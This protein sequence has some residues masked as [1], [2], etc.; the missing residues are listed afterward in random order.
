MEQHWIYLYKNIRALSYCFIF[1][2]VLV[3]DLLAS[4][5]NG[6]NFHQDSCREY[7]HGEERILSVPFI[8]IEVFSMSVYS[9]QCRYKVKRQ[10][11]Q[12]YIASVAL[13]FS[14][15]LIYFNGLVPKGQ[16]HEYYLKKVRGCIAK[17]NHKIIGENGKQILINIED[18][19]VVRETN[20]S[21]PQHSIQIH[22]QYNILSS[23]KSFYAYIGCTGIFHEIMHYFCLGDEYNAHLGQFFPLVSRDTEDRTL[24]DCRV[25]QENSIMSGSMNLIK[26]WSIVFDDP[27]DHGFQWRSPLHCEE[28]TL[29]NED[30]KYSLLDPT[31]FNAILYGN[32]SS[33]DDV[34]HYREC[35][36]LAF[37]NSSF[38]FNCLSQK[39]QCE[40]LNLLG[41]DK[42]RELERLY[43]ESY[44]LQLDIGEENEYLV[45]NLMER[46]FL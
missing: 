33:R 40:T 26:R 1:T 7:A 22:T 31:H 25:T 9:M 13:E 35:M 19:R 28:P 41:R 46:F 34:R 11:S 6:P 39:H 12:T 8:D 16:V 38:N 43:T 27:L 18:A 3:K 32:C 23:F 37:Q 5:A 45:E 44:S 21:T 14:P 20:S 15:S 17:S 10:T 29:S 42:N 2:F 4:Q 30:I 24:F 36:R